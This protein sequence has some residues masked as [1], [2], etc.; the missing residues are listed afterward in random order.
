M[1]TDR[2]CQFSVADRVLSDVPLQKMTEIPLDMAVRD[3]PVMSETVRY[4]VDVLRR[5]YQA[6]SRQPGQH[7]RNQSRSDH[8]GI[9]FGVMIARNPYR[10][11]ARPENAAWPPWGGLFRARAAAVHFRWSIFL[12]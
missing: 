8:A 5:Q 6:D 12:A 10:R 2:Q 11:A 1:L 3:Q 7:E 9:I 4:L